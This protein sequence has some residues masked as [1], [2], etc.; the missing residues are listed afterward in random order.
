MLALSKIPWIQRMVMDMVRVCF[1]VCLFLC[2]YAHVSAVSWC[3]K[4]LCILSL[5]C[6][7]NTP[8]LVF[9]LLDLFPAL[10]LCFYSA[11][12][13]QGLSFQWISTWQ[14]KGLLLNFHWLKPLLTL[15]LSKKHN[16]LRHMV[17]AEKREMSEIEKRDGG[18]EG[19]GREAGDKP[20]KGPALENAY[21]DGS[22]EIKMWDSVDIHSLSLFSKIECNTSSGNKY[23]LN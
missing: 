12:R 3:P 19:S 10:S 1:N 22:V 8:F 15:K 5:S 16:G 4:K 18:R 6:M 2:T 23:V 7:A 13:R 11:W 17:W 21:L 14:R 9:L 20:H